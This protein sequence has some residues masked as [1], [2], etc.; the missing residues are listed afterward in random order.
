MGL[1]DRFER[2]LLEDPGLEPLELRET[3]L[4]SRS[5]FVQDPDF[6]RPL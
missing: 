5:K 2:R 1:A 4:K 3:G 6:G